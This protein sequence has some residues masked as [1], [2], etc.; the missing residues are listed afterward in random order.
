VY[1]RGFVDDIPNPCTGVHPLI[2]HGS[3]RHT[4]SLQSRNKFVETALGYALTYSSA[5]N[6]AT[7]GPTSITILADTDYY[8]HPGSSGSPTPPTH[9]RFLDF[10]VPLDQAHKTGLG[11]SAALVTA[12]T[13]AVVAHYAPREVTSAQSIHERT[14]LH[15]LA[16]AA[17]CAAQGK[18]GSGFDVAA[19]T[20]GSCVYRRFS[21]SILEGLGDIG[22]KDFS[23]RLKS[24][25]EDAD[26][27]KKWDTSIDRDFAAS[28]PQNLRLL[29]CDVD[30]GSETVGMVRNV[31]SW[32]KEKPEQAILLWET[33][34]RGNED[35]AK[36]LHELANKDTCTAEGYENLR[37]IIL[38]IR[39]LIRE[40]STKSGVPVEPK[41]QTDLIDACCRI[42]G[43][44]GGVVPGAGGFDA[45][46]LLVEDKQEIIDSLHQ[47]FENY[48]VDSD[49]GQGIG[50]GK[51]RLLG[52]KQEDHGVKA[53]NPSQ[54]KGWLR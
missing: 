8:S 13:T 53:E 24:V 28:V 27:S 3:G 42:P 32:K 1:S 37:T 50:I 23:T 14:R 4:T 6:H 39:S 2:P 40:M 7:I 11:S 38:T 35:L 52:V 49:Y 44:V 33:L 19:A 21:P 10:N 5:V 22:V 17:H 16:Q 26:P 51:I 9:G 29:M 46:V 34:H 47:F 36:E 15:N 20:Y 18:I 48:R 25:V 45:I 41:A 31:L 54:F 43:V 12:L 30:C